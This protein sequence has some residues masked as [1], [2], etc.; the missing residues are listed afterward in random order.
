MW[1]GG[2]AGAEED[3]E[4]GCG[5]VGRAERKGSER[6]GGGEKAG[7]STRSKVRNGEGWRGVRMEGDGGRETAS[8]HRVGDDT[9]GVEC[10]CPRP[11][12]KYGCTYVPQLRGSGTH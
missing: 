10:P 7:W 4:G 1:A 3:G 8:Q 6:R 9:R 11:H 12:W 2:R 5:D